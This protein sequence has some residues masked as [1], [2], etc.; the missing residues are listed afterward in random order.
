MHGMAEARDAL[1]EA[2]ERPASGIVD[3]GDA[4]GMR[5]REFA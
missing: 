3:N 1:M 5:E 4:V 2:P